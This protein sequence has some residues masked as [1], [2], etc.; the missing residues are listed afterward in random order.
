MFNERDEMVWAKAIPCASFDHA[1][2]GGEV[3]LFLASQV[4]AA[5]VFFNEQIGAGVPKDEVLNRMSTE[6][7]KTHQAGVN[8]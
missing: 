5:V 6:V 8:D 7:E 3:D 4:D 2:L 1:V